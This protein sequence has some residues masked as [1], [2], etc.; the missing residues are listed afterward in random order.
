MPLLCVSWHSLHSTAA[1]FSSG[2]LWSSRHQPL[3]R[4]LFPVLSP[5]LKTSHPVAA[6][7][8]HFQNKHRLNKPYCIRPYHCDLSGVACAFKAGLA[9]PGE[10]ERPD[11]SNVGRRD[12]ESRISVTI[13]PARKWRTNG[14]MVGL[15]KEAVDSRRCCSYKTTTN[16]RRMRRAW[17]DGVP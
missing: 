9:G 7:R 13:L 4:L 11:D 17:R 6:L 15:P 12:C 5:R 16:Q 8:S 14:A 10:S 1:D 2:T 3:F